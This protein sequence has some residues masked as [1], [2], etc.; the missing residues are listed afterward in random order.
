MA[1]QV[2][3]ENRHYRECRRLEAIRARLAWEPGF[4]NG[5][6]R[7]PAGMHWRTYYRLKAEHDELVASVVGHVDA[8]LI[9]TAERLGRMR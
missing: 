9:R 2:Q 1:Y 8:R 6:D 3:R 4:L 5:D 7:K